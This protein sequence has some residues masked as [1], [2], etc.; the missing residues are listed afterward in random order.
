LSLL[1]N[2]SEQQPAAARFLAGGSPT[3]GLLTS[4][5]RHPWQ[6]GGLRRQVPEGV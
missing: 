5:T 3:S 2:L 6:G 1:N 4:R